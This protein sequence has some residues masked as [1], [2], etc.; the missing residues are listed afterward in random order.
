MGPFHAPTFDLACA[1]AASR[2]SSPP[3][4]PSAASSHHMGVESTA[5][6]A[7]RNTDMKQRVRGRAITASSRTEQLRA[8][9]NSPSSAAASDRDI[10]AGVKSVVINTAVCRCGVPG[11]IASDKVALCHG[12]AA[13]WRRHRDR[14]GPTGRRGDGHRPQ[15]RRRGSQKN[16][17]RIARAVE[18]S[19]LCE[20]SRN[21]DTQ[22]HIVA[23]LLR[24][25]ARCNYAVNNAGISG[26]FAPARHHGS[27][28]GAA[29]VNVNLDAIFYGMKFQL[30]A[31]MRPAAARWSTA[32][33]FTPPRS[34]RLDAYTAASRGAGGLTR[35]AGGRS[36]IDR[37]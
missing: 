24:N 20:M 21:V 34:A 8:Q 18:R 19:L 29:W 3:P 31:A 28:T 35:S 4:P 10:M 22:E 30:P 7:V 26:L 11:G 33:R 9:S 15:R 12:A 36:I 25:L 17:A 1:A 16:G 6:Q 23:T 13:V 2:P 27:M 37:V 14:I 32:L 5:R